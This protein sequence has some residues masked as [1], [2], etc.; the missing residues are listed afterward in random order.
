M[1]DTTTSL[2]K[3]SYQAQGPETRIEPNAINA[4]SSSLESARELA[5]RVD[6]LVNRLCGAVPQAVGQAVEPKA[7]P[8]LGGLRQ[9]AERT[10]EMIRNAQGQLN[11]L[12]REVM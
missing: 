8:I 9:D 2:S 1:F 3:A 5:N 4:A 10:A 11:R 6:D 12:E 7:G